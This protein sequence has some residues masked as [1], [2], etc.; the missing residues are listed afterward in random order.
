M[1]RSLTEP[2]CSEFCFP[3]LDTHVRVEVS[4]ES[5]TIRATRD[6][7]SSIRKDFFVRELAAEGFIPD[8]YRWASQA[9]FGVSYGRVRWLVDFGWLA[10]SEEILAKSRRFALRLFAVALA[11]NLLLLELGLAGRLGYAS[12]EAGVGKRAA[13]QMRQVSGPSLGSVGTIRR[14]GIPDSKTSSP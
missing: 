1:G 11:L 6:T 12:P 8:Q 7:F 13:V 3:R 4:D 9:D 10:I 14:R 2:T 5:V